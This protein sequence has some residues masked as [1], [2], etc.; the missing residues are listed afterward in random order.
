M[1]ANDSFTTASVILAE[2]LNTSSNMNEQEI[3][4]LMALLQSNARSIVERRQSQIQQTNVRPV[5]RPINR[6][7]NR[8]T[9]ELRPRVTVY[10]E[11]FR[12]TARER[13]NALRMIPRP[14]TIKTISKA[15]FSS[16]CENMCSICHDTHKKGDSVTTQ[17]EH[18]FGKQCWDTWMEN[19]YS[20]RKCPNCR[21]VCYRIT[22]YKTRT[23][24]AAASS[25][26]QRVTNEEETHGQ[27]H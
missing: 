26:R 17:C 11:T 25:S 18:H 22:T 4:A 3:E 12:A 7:I 16:D 1:S 19:P 8:P 27:L 14:P 6:P 9:A 13:L 10:D 21:E 24:S 2:L 15:N 23:R 5:H 20:N